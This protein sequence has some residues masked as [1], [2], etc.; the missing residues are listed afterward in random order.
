M[1]KPVRRLV[2]VAILG[3]IAC[4]IGIDRLADG[5]FP[6]AARTLYFKATG[7]MLVRGLVL[8]LHPGDRV[9]T[10][11][12][13]ATGVW[14]QTETELFLREVGPGDVVIDVGANVGYYT[15]LAAN[16][17][18]AEGKVIAFEPDPDNF[19]YLKKSVEAN[20]FKNVVLE[21]KALSNAPGSVSLYLNDQNKGDHRLFPADERRSS[22]TVEAIAFD[23]YDLGGRSVSFIKIDTQGAEGAILEGMLRTLRANR[24][25][26]L[27]VEFWPHGLTLA[28]YSARQLAERFTE[29][30]FTQVFEISESRRSVE[31]TSF[32]ALIEQHTG[33]ETSFTNIHISR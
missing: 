10:R 6:G 1:Q 20:G 12:L 22:T 19:S 33:I 16:E 21:Q 18:G 26:D 3:A 11:E 8:H 29:L 25:V 17:V 2:V 32:D 31:R 4:G 23:D 5:G 24:D 13:L 7:T 15:V 28:G 27:A 14:E 30:S 9:I